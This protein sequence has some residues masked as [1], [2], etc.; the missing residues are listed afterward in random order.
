M[1]C[2]W[3]AHELLNQRGCLIPPTCPTCQVRSALL[4]VVRDGA[5]EMP[6]AV[7]SWFAGAL[8]RCRAIYLHAGPPGLHAGPPGLGAGP[9]GLDAAGHT[10]RTMAHAYA[11]ASR[12]PYYSRGRAS[13]SYFPNTA[14]ILYIRFRFIAPTITA[15]QR[16][17]AF[18]RDSSRCSRSSVNCRASVSCRLSTAGAR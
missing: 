13:L 1:S 9:P 11:H 2:S 18:A 16:C 5:A 17:E 15:P 4:C 7:S 8:N 3:V 6:P 12:R 14:L 10:A